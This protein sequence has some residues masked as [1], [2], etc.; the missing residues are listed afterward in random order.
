MRGEGATASPRTALLGARRIFS[1]P[2]PPAARLGVRER[3]Y[4]L[5]PKD[6]GGP[7]S[8]VL[9]YTSAPDSEGTL[10]GLVRL[11]EQD[12]LGRHVGEALDQM[13]LCASDLLCT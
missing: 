2:S 6:E 1:L 9:L 12:E 3:I 4:A 13:R 10:G 5:R 8:G 11:G 7:L